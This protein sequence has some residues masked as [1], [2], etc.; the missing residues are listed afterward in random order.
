MKL[1]Y[2]PKLLIRYQNLMVMTKEFDLVVTSL[3]NVM[4][5]LKVEM[6]TGIH[7]E[8]VMVLI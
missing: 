7:L 5:M 8:L 3:V 6:K 1:L 4:V 2:S